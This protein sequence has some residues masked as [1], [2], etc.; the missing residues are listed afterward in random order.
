MQAFTAPASSS[1]QRLWFLDRIDP[2]NGAYHIPVALRFRGPIDRETLAAA[3]NEII[4][5]HEVLRTTFASS[6]GEVVQVVHASLPLTL[7]EETVAG[8]E[9][10]AEAIRRGIHQPFDL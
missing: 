8:D 5:R 9:A 3:L 2:A 1:Q 7:R 4:A 6:D 10:L